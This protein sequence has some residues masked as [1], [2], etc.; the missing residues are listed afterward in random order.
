MSEARLER[1]DAAAKRIASRQAHRPTCPV[2]VKSWGTAGELH[3]ALQRDPCER[4]N[5]LTGGVAHHLPLSI[6][7]DDDCQL[8]EWKCFSQANGLDRAPQAKHKTDDDN[9]DAGACQQ[10]TRCPNSCRPADAEK[11]HQQAKHESQRVQ[12]ARTAIDDVKRW[13]TF[14]DRES[15]RIGQYRIRVLHCSRCSPL[16]GA[17]AR[18]ARSRR[19]DK[20]SPPWLGSGPARPTPRP[21]EVPFGSRGSGAYR[22][23]PTADH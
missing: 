5:G 14:N 13:A 20:P 15:A 10:T 12:S 3:L 4:C 18:L 23:G 6:E 1:A 21:A 2:Q 8:L 7:G 17:A 11:R 9:C 16:C 19:R 22:P